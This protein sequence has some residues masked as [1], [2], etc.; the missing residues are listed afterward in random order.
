MSFFS[1]YPSIFSSSS[2]TSASTFTSYDPSVEGY[3]SLLLRPID[4]ME[5]GIPRGVDIAMW[6]CLFFVFVVEILLLF[7]EMEIPLSVVPPLLWQGLGSFAVMGSCFYRLGVAV[8][9]VTVDGPEV[10]HRSGNSLSAPGG[11]GGSVAWTATD[12][13]VAVDVT[14]FTNPET[15]V[16]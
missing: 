4:P 3:T 7:L 9:R 1:F 8:P 14:T 15:P 6:R 12:Y 11:P 16:L 2:S 10:L 5:G 13:R